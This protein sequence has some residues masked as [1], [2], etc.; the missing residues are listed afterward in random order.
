MNQGKDKS[1]YESSKGKSL[2]ALPEIN[3]SPRSALITTEP[4]RSPHI[5]EISQMYALSTPDISPEAL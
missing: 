1:A 5:K 2:N 4:T 3:G